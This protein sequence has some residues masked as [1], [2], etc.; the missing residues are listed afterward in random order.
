MSLEVLLEPIDKAHRRCKLGAIIAS[1]EEPYQ[2]ALQKL[3]DVSWR[4]GG[5]SDTRL[6][7]RLKLA[8]FSVSMSVIYNHRTGVCACKG[9]VG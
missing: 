8:G 9:V 3:A 1:L 7:E 6:R 2:S 4:E 5:L